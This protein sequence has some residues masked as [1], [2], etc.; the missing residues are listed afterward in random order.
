MSYPE[1]FRIAQMPQIGSMIQGFRLVDFGK[2]EP[3]TKK[4]VIHES[5]WFKLATDVS[6]SYVLPAIAVTYLDAKNNEKS[7]ATNEIFVEVSVPGAKDPAGEKKKDETPADI[8]DI[9]PV[10]SQDL[11]L[12]WALIGSG[13]ALIFVAAGGIYLWIKKRRLRRAEPTPMAAHEKAL[14][15]LNSLREER[16]LEARD[17][18]KFHFKLSFIIR[19]YFE[20]RTGYPATDRTTHE[21]K[22]G[23]RDTAEFHAGQKEEFVRILN[24]ADLVKFTDHDAA[25]GENVHLLMDAI[26]FVTETAPISQAEPQ[27]SVV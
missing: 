4:G 25:R 17:V 21:I 26:K 14:Q 5:Q 6:G 18:K 2:S 3:E 13:L 22:R 8:R 1:G 10:A 9:K 16:I 23:M 20:E 24:H 15:A 7:A 12:L 11:T 27:E 19:Q